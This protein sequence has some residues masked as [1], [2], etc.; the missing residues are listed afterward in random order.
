MARRVFV[1]GVFLISLHAH[2][3]GGQE[4]LHPAAGRRVYDGPPLTL[5]AAIDEALQRNPALVALRSEFEAARQRPAQER[6][7][8]PP[9]FEAEIWQWPLTS[10]NPLNTDMYMFTVR[11]DLPGRGKRALR[12]A[13]LDKDAEKSSNDI[14]IRA[15]EVVNQVKQTYADLFVSRQAVAAHEASV[16]LLRQSADLIMVRYGAG[17]GEQQDVLKTVTEISKLHGDL[18]MLE[19]Q[20]DLAAVQLNTLL[21][22]PPGSPI[23]ELVPEAGAGDLALPPLEELQRLAV[24]RHPELRAVQIDIERA[25]AALAVVA[26]DAKPDFMVGGGY[27]LMPRSAGAW[28]AMGGIT[29][30]NA[31]W[32]RGRLDAAK[33]LADADIAT[34]KAMEQAVRAGI[35]SAIQQ[36]YIRVTSANTRV[37][38]LRDSVIPQTE[39]VFESSRIAYQAER[40]EAVALVENQRMLLDAQLDYYRG[41]SDLQQARADLERAV[42]ADLP[43]PISV[44]SREGR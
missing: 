37:E 21:S 36:A 18:V 28:T 19:E 30:P 13:A 8:M 1:L 5:S 20:A 29:W 33:A 44:A 9:T 17:K 24:E 31:P 32:S 16:D 15:R 27:Q 7:L 2:G 6:F 4:L 34:A 11:Q 3:A 41:L 12:A 38:L 40:G 22:R 14:V 26:S 35:A 25:E 23:G 10:V 42:G 43:P 39:Q